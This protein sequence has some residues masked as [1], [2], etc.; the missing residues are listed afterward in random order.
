MDD[1]SLKKS[2]RNAQFSNLEEKFI[3][4]NIVIVEENDQDEMDN[5]INEDLK[6]IRSSF[7]FWYMVAYNAVLQSIPYWH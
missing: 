4:K 6:S 1:F 3:D 2:S 7:I 5:L